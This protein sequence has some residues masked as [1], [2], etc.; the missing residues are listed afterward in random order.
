MKNE[1]TYLYPIRA[2]A[3]P[4]AGVGVA[5]TYTVESVGVDVVRVMCTTAGTLTFGGT[6]AVVALAPNIFEYFRVRPG[7][8]LTC[9]AA[10]NVASMT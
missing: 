10:T 7:E 8:V 5:G 4:A 1:A 9:S 3:V 2:V 6:G